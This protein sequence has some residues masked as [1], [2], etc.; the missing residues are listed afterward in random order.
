[1][2]ASFQILVV[3]TDASVRNALCEYLMRHGYTVRTARDGNE[4]NRHLAEQK[5]D[6]IV[7]DWM[8]PGEDGLSIC[9]R[10]A[11]D[12]TTVLMLSAMCTTLDRVIGL[13]VG[14]D[15][16]LSKP[17]DPR[18]LLA[19]VRALLRRRSK[20]QSATAISRVH[21]DGWRF[22]GAER[23]LLNPDGQ[24]V[25]LTPLEC[26]LLR[27]FVDRAGRLLS[28][29]RLMQLTH[30]DDSKAFD[31]AMDL[32]VSRLRRKLHWPGCCAPIETVRGEGYR[33]NVT[34]ERL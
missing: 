9:R 11:A 3:D 23:R 34:V 7:L 33:F 30:G 5:A 20:T 31:R 17:F 1:M 10:L 26:N 24:P 22:E 32:A 4:M 27:V 14:A 15:D 12:G 8:M 18:E 2:S 25:A 21:F 19:R 29:D 28:R 6:L 13:E 16:Y